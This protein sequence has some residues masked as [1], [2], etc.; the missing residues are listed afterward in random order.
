LPSGVF[1]LLARRLDV[2]SRVPTAAL[3]V[4]CVLLATGTVVRTR[5]YQSVRSIAQTNVDRYPHGRARLALASELVAV[6]EH[7]DALRQLQEAVKDY[8]QAPSRWPPRWR[9]RAASPTR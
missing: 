3:A 6:N 4:V 5:E 2:D 7:T 9:R 1:R 8:P